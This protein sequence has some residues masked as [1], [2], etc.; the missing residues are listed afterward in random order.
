M[1]KTDPKTVW[2]EFREVKLKAGR[3]PRFTLD[4]YWDAL[5]QL[6]R[7]YPNLKSIEDF[8]AEKIERWLLNLPVSLRSK[9]VRRKQ[10]NVFFN[11]C[12]KRGLIGE[13]PVERVETITAPKANREAFTPREI[14]KLKQLAGGDLKVA[15]EYLL[16]GFRPAEFCS[17]KPENLD[18]EAGVIRVFR[19]KTREF[20]NIELFDRLKEMIENVKN[21]GLDAYANPDDEKGARRKQWALFKDFKALCKKAG[22]P[23]EKAIL[24]T[25]R[26]TAATKLAAE[27]QD[28]FRLMSQMGWTNIRQAETYVHGSQRTI[29]A[30]VVSKSNAIAEMNAKID[31]I[32][33]WVEKFEEFKSFVET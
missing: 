25:L 26:H 11:W 24:Y 28:P 32:L 1:V 9:A 14:E 6:F 7:A 3:S 33:A 20:Q 30:K 31:K 2:E 13:N 5:C 27:W 18:L 10:I 19:R 16:H 23:N 29:W 15:I 8:T 22:V 21:F 12:S 4:N 17:L